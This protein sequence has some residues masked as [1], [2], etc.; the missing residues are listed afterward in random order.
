MSEETEKLQTGDIE[1]TEQAL[2]DDERG[3]WTNKLD[4]VMA[5]VGFAVGLGNI[6]RFPYLCYKNGGGKICLFVSF[7]V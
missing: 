4:F 5:C 1:F 2:P 6:W 3:K 7:G